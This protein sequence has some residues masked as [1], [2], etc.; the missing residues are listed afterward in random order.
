MSWLR[1]LSL[2]PQGSLLRLPGL[3]TWDRFKIY[4][5]GQVRCFSM[6]PL[7]LCC[8]AP[9]S[10]QG[11]QISLRRVK[12]QWFSEGSLLIRVTINMRSTLLTNFKCSWHKSVEHKETF[13][14]DGYVYYLDCDDDFTG[15]VHMS[16]LIKLC[17][18]NMLFLYINYTSIFF[19]KLFIYLAAL[20]LCCHMRAFS[21]CGEQG[22]LFV[23]VCR[24]LTAVASLVAEHGL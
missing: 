4:L 11:S 12:P 2:W 18:V 17:K 15:C 6:S 7:P 16:K 14:G 10:H 13:G 9:S 23:V 21:S 1:G 24:L 3:L 8:Q 19:F 5:P 20:G 22:L